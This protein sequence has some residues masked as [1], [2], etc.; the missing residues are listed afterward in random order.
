MGRKSPVVI[1][2]GA[3]SLGVPHSSNCGEGPGFLV[4]LAILTAVLRAIFPE[5]R[6]EVLVGSPNRDGEVDSLSSRIEEY[7]SRFRSEPTETVVRELAQTFIARGNFFAERGKSLEAEGDYLKALEL[8]REFQDLFAP[9]ESKHRLAGTLNN[10]GRVRRDAGTLSEGITTFDQALGVLDE[11]AGDGPD[12]SD[13]LRAM[14]LNN[15]GIAR[16]RLQD[17][18]GA[19]GDFTASVEFAHKSF[20]KRQDAKSASALIEA[21][22]NRGASYSHSGRHAE[23]LGDYNAALEWC[24]VLSELDATASRASFARCL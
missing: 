23:A 7:G 18:D 15:R 12:G 24:R 22:S 13:L 8:F 19:V 21:L 1:S 4:A 10:L 9:D 3:F 5:R 16:V 20:E 6:K 11:S 2:E 17:S 14:I